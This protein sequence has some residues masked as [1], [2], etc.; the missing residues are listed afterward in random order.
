VGNEG[1][2]KYDIVYALTYSITISWPII[3]KLTFEQQLF[4][5]NSY[6]KFHENLTDHLVTD[7]MSLIDGQ[8]GG[9]G[10][11]VFHKEHLKL[12]YCTENSPTLQEYEEW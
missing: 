4:A 10:L 3:T 7:T 9:H 1:K 6:T 5:K 8:V 11:C 12:L 2:C